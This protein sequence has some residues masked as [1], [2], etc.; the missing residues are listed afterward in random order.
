[1]KH[2]EDSVSG[3]REVFKVAGYEDLD[4]GKL[5]TNIPNLIQARLKD[6]D[7]SEVKHH[8][9]FF[10][11]SKDELLVNEN[12]LSYFYNIDSLLSG[13]YL[14]SLISRIEWFKVKINDFSSEACRE[15]E[16]LYFNNEKEGRKW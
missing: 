5:K 14:D 7:Q 4:T 6:R 16:R 12:N 15:A 11:I 3:I 13:S 10:S 8:L 1:M 9:V 2:K